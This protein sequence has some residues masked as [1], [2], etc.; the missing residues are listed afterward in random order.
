MTG[1]V[2]VAEG[3]E[4]EKEAAALKQ[5]KLCAMADCAECTLVPLPQEYEECTQVIETCTDILRESLGLPEDENEE[6][7]RE[8]TDGTETE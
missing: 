1:P 2:N 3:S 4:H 5:L 7:G 6:R 8:V